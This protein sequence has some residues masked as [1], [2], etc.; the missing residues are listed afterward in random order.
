MPD[1]VA[2]I[3]M[4]GDGTP[5]REFTYVTDFANWIVTSSSFLN[6]LPYFLNTGIGID[7]SVLDYY[8]KVLLTLKFDAKITPNILMP[9]GN[10]RKLLDSSIARGFGW[11]PVT[12][13]DKGIIETIDWLLESRLVN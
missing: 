8:T 10:S 7:Y 11:N 4:W 9:N 2:S 6:K 12:G 3:K 13:I 5:R 1:L